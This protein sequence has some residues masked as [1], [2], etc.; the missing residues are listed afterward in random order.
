[1]KEMDAETADAP[2]DNART[3]QTS[4][5]KTRRRTSG[6]RAVLTPR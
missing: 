1:M 3:S 4:P 6:C 2:S 5:T